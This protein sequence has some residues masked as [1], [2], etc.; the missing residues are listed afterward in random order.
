MPEPDDKL[1]LDV[2]YQIYKKFGKFPEAIRVALRMDNSEV[3]MIS[4]SLVS[5]QCALKFSYALFYCLS[6]QNTSILPGD[7]FK[8]T[9]GVV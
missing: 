4:L 2:A 8:A 7:S 3:E 9:L 6:A 1:V 5:A